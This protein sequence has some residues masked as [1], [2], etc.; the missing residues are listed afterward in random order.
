MKCNSALKHNFKG[1]NK[2]CNPLQGKFMDLIISVFYSNGDIFDCA[3]KF[4]NSI[5]FQWK[6]KDD[7]LEIS[8]K[9]PIHYNGVD[10]T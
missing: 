9:I 2:K 6:I 8:G 3:Y 7:I 10:L 1:C 5:T 4:I